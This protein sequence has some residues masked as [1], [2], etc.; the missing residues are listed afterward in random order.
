M[1][2]EK[3]KVLFVLVS[4]NLLAIL[5]TLLLKTNFLTSTIL[6]LGIPS[7]YLLTKTRKYIIKILIASISFGVFFS[8]VFDF[9][10]ELNGAWDWNGGLLFGSILGVVQIDVM[11]W[12]FL[13]ILHVLLFY[14]YF[15]D[16]NHLNALYSKIG[17]PILI[18][19]IFSVVGLLAIY[20]YLP[21]VL[22]F[23]YAYLKV[24]LLILIPLLIILV[25]KPKLILHIIPSSIYFIFVYLSHELT[26]LHLNQ[27]RFPG[28][29][30]GWINLGGV[31][32]PVEE[33]IF[34]IILSSLV[35]STYYE[36]CFDNQRN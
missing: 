33:L 1:N 8:F 35:V 20:F 6:F 13:W 34:W 4:I 24:C 3:K 2:S 5:I 22:Y 27:W 30:I 21:S 23:G 17:L 10:N 19:S 15:V 29:Y 28:D 11:V 18:L 36:I 9:I 32:F 25:K 7:F 16:K 12:F 14:E 26:A 31:V